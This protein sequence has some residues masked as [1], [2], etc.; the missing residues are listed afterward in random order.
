MIKT[1]PRVLYQ[2]PEEAG[3]PFCPPNGTDGEI[4]EEAFCFNCVRDQAFQNNEGDSCP[5]AFDVMMW[6]V[7]DPRYPKEWVFDSEG[8][9]VCT[10]FEEVEE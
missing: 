8:W 4:F 7:D 2:F 6:P 1:H 9:P 3:K 5:I 10:A